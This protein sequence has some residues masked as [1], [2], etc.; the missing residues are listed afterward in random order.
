MPSVTK[1]SIHNYQCIKSAKL[2]DGILS[3]AG[4]A[5][6]DYHSLDGHEIVYDIPTADLDSFI[7]L[8]GLR[9][10][11]NH[12]RIEWDA[13]RNRIVLIRIRDGIYTYLQHA[14]LDLT[15]EPSL[16]I[17]WSQSS[18]RLFS[19]ALCFINVLAEDLVDGRWGFA[20][21]SQPMRLPEVTIKVN[22]APL[23]QWIILGD[24]YSNNRWK[25]RDFYSWPELAFGDKRP[26]LN[27][28]VA[29]GNTRRVLEIAHQ[30]GAEFTG[31]KVIL[32]VGADD[33]ME[34]E[35]L[36][37][38]ISRI[39]EIATLAQS[40]G[41]AELHICSILPKPKH[42]SG[43]AAWNAAIAELS[44]PYF[45]SCIDFHKIIASASSELLVHGDYPGAEAQR[46]MAAAVLSHVNLPGH[47]A[48][49][50]C[51]CHKP[52]LNGLPARIAIRLG[53]A[54]DQSLGRF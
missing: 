7:F 45:D 52:L 34:G 30:I 48:P 20:G 47:L 24:G 18:I 10:V 54:I 42:H 12:Y 49:L 39:T 14:Y 17:R 21:R 22:P 13:S 4:F 3:G 50:E 27:A 43:L 53:G 44:H 9:G 46:A 32:A 1:P 35:T 5:L 28:C 41:A 2:T 37:D 31:S 26:Y 33:F 8:F 25:N 19:G 40:Q 15:K 38:A 16:F 6:A 23:Y 51:P 36:A 29:A 11:G